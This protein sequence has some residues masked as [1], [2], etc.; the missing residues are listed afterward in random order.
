VIAV[1]DQWLEELESAGF[2]RNPL[3]ARTAPRLQLNGLPDSEQN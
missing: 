3:L 1:I 2:T